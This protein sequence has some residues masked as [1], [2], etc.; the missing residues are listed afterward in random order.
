M[1]EIIRDARFKGLEKGGRIMKGCASHIFIKRFSIVYMFCFVSV[2]LNAVEL[3]VK[4]YPVENGKLIT[5]E[6]CEPN[7]EQIWTQDKINSI[8]LKIGEKMR[9]LTNSEMVEVTLGDL[10]C[11]AEG[12]GGNYLSIDL[13]ESASDI[14]TVLALLKDS[15][16]R[17]LRQIPLEMHVDY[18]GSCDSFFSKVTPHSEE[19]NLERCRVVHVDGKPTVLLAIRGWMQ[20]NGHVIY[21]VFGQV[22]SKSKEKEIFDEIDFST[23][24]LWPLSAFKD[25]KGI[26]FLVWRKA[27]GL[28]CPRRV[29]V[30][31]SKLESLD[32]ESFGPEWQV[33]GQTCGN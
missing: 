12:C 19:E 1:S 3:D 7:I 16:G 8:G 29:T 31:L 11:F 2:A 6:T 17:G 4:I 25:E 15:D 10:T 26:P 30:K 18:D 13:K 33:G 22:I 28:C 14:G 32:P 20:E 27:E 24:P 23:D 21:R 5:Q 9:A